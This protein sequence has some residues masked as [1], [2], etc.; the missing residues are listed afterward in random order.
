MWDLF[1]KEIWFNYFNVLRLNSVDQ[2]EETKTYQKELIDRLKHRETLVKYKITGKSYARIYF[3]N[4]AEDAIWYYSV[5][6]KI[7][8]EACMMKKTI[9]FI[10]C[11]RNYFVF[12]AKSKI[13]CKFVMVLRRMYGRIVYVERKSHLTN[14]NMLFQYFIVIIVIR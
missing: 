12:K 2:F 14:Q 3:L 13:S 1:R 6:H 11:D 9:F 10:Y 7:K 4:Q 8:R 5:K